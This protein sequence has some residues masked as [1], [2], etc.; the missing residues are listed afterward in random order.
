MRIGMM[1]WRIG[2]KLDLFEQIAWIREN[3]FKEV[4]FHAAPGDDG[5]WQGF[6]PFGKT[7][8]EIER[9]CAA[10][11]AFEESD[12]HA[13]FAPYDIFLAARNPRVLKTCLHEIEMS[14][15]L[16]DRIGAETVTIHADVSPG[17]ARDPKAR[18]MMIESLKRLGGSAAKSDVL[19]GV[20]LSGDYEIV[21]ETGLPNVGLTLDVGHMS[22]AGGEG[23]RDYGSIGGVIRAFADRVF[24][25]HIHDYDGVHDHLGI[26]K[27]NINFEEILTPLHA[28]GYKGSLC[29]ELSPDRNTPEEMVQSRDRL[30][31][32]IGRMRPA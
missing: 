25:M 1:A 3:G 19:I 18:G 22:A 5:V 4:G 14:I 30:R 10:V 31:E 15:A 29:L 16:A 26:G 9:L 24:L 12:I 21:R 2:D 6:C 20:E 32:I 17:M 27:G 8:E 23:C 28:I 13:P 11:S 7:E